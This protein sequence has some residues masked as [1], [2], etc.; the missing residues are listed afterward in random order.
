MSDRDQLSVAFAALADPTRRDILVRLRAGPSPVG[1]L[2]THYPIS[3]PAVSQ[4]LAVLERAGLVRR[5]RRAQRNDCSLTPV[6]LDAAAAWIERQRAEWT[7]RFDLLDEHFRQRRDG[8]ARPDDHETHESAD[9]DRMGEA[10]E[11][12]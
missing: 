11:G 10:G 2:A 12:R 5:D 8:G 7:D 1:E 6:G 4:H 9:R 3:R